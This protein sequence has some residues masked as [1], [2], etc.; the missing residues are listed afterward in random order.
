MFP[1][2]AI[3][4]TWVM[5]RTSYEKWCC[6]TRHEDFFIVF[7]KQ[8]SSLIKM[9]NRPRLFFSLQ[10]E[11]FT[12]HIVCK[13]FTYNVK[14]MYRKKERKRQLDQITL[15]YSNQWVLKNIY[16][17]SLTLVIQSWLYFFPLTLQYVDLPSTRSQVMDPRLFKGK[18]A[19]KNIA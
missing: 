10:S 6:K 12:F 8:I 16:I 13:T 17:L 2:T 15:C 5:S 3:A 4:L 7:N 19:D 14:C 1:V 9:Q 18:K 11:S